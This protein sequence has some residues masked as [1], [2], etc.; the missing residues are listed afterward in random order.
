MEYFNS[1]IFCER[2]NTLFEKT[3][4]KELSKKLGISQS[5]ISDIMNGNVKSPRA[6]TIF[7]IANHFGV[8]V[9]WLLGL[10]DVKSTDKATKELCDTLGINEEAIEVLK[11][12]T[13]I[14]ET[15][16]FLFYQDKV[17]K[18][19]QDINNLNCAVETVFG[20]DIWSRFSIL[21]LLTEFI[22]L[23]NTS[24]KDD[25]Y[26]SITPDGAL[27]LG[28]MQFDG[29]GEIDGVK[30]EKKIET[31]LENRGFGVSSMVA[32]RMQRIINILT[33]QLQAFVEDKIICAIDANKEE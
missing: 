28:K 10:S 14:N 25:I 15:L 33:A 11:E 7:S 9:D 12:K 1:N 2:V 26:Y 22:E 31:G 13:N 29:E 19:F 32:Y 20:I 30:M 5:L 17:C 24:Y 21:E 27:H 16:N 3:G 18:K 4:Q 6:D 23:A 8:S